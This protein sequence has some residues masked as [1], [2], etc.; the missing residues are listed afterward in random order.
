MTLIVVLLTISLIVLLF[1]ITLLYL[2]PT[3]TLKR[4]SKEDFL[5]I[6]VLVAFKNEEKNL[7]NLF[8][9]LELLNYSQDKFEVILVD[10]GSTD[11]SY[12]QAV[13][14]ANGQNNYRVLQAN[15]KKF[16]GKKGALNIGIS[17]ARYPFIVITDADCMPAKN[18]LLGYSEKFK[19]DYDLLFGLAPFIQTDGLI[20]K[21]SCFEN[22]RSSMLTFAFAKLKLPYSAAARNLGFKKSSFEKLGGFSNTMQTISGDDDLLIREAVKQ[23]MNIG[24][25]N[26]E[27]S[28]VLSNSKTTFRNYLN[29]KSRHTKTSFYYLPIHKFLLGLWHSSNILML[30]TLFLLP[31]NIFLIVPFLIK[32]FIDFIVVWFTQRKLKYKFKLYE[33]PF[34]QMFYELF[35]IL[36]FFLSFR[37]N[38]PWKN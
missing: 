27:N 17:N 24:I 34:L 2:F 8:S 33:I 37:R 29:Q 14:L 10:D 12:Q 20:N 3:F 6:S 35:L 18:W 1:N 15:D 5:N 13:K 30:F 22:L 11:H 9:S 21:I 36:N 32:L 4:I 19:D 16:P 23:N 26:I 28:F 31:L 7:E 38:I 25:V